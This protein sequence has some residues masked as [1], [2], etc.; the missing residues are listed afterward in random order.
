MV[1]ASML[2]SPLSLLGIPLILA[3]IVVGAWGDSGSAAAQP[4]P[5]WRRVVLALIFT[6]LT[7]AVVATGVLHITVW[8][9]LAK[10]P[11]L[12]LDEI[13]AAMAAAN[14]S[15]FVFCVAG[16]AIFWGVAAVIFVIL[17]GLPPLRTFFTARRIVVTGLLL[18]GVTTGFL[19]WAGFNMGMSLADTFRTSG[20]DAAISDPVLAILG[21][22][23]LVAA[24]LIGLPPRRH[25][26]ELALAA[27]SADS[28]T[29]KAGTVTG[30]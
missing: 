16:W 14:E 20:G 12:S 30:G 7:L 10:V 17:A 29:G 25:R 5:T 1:L 18:V 24:L 28:V 23:V 21:Q 6:L 8:N 15:P 19:F 26:V 27:A 13:F 11:G 4:L 22:L 9:P 3:V 2:V